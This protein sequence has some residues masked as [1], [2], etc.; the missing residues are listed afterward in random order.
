[1]RERSKVPKFRMT[2][3][4]KEKIRQGGRCAGRGRRLRGGAGKGRVAEEKGEKRR[5]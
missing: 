3:K 4:E 5:I 2:K 1:M